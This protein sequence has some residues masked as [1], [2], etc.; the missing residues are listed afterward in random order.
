MFALFVNLWAAEDTSSIIEES[1]VESADEELAEELEE[2]IENPINI[3]KATVEELQAIPDITPV[4]AVNIVKTR[5]SL[6]KFSNEDDLMKVPGMS[7]EIL[8]R[9][10]PF[11]V[12]QET[13][14]QKK[15]VFRNVVFDARLRYLYFWKKDEFPKY[16]DKFYFR[17]R[18]RL[19]RWHQFGTLLEKDAGEY[20]YV[21]NYKIS[22]YSKKLLFLSGLALGN[23]RIRVGQGLVLSDSTSG[24]AMPGYAVKAAKKKRVGLKMDLSST[25]NAYLFGIGAK[26][27]TG[28]VEII[29]FFSRNRYDASLNDDGTVKTLFPS[30]LDGVHDTASALEKKDRLTDTSF[31]ADVSI[32]IGTAHRI[33]FTYLKSLLSPPRGLTEEEILYP[34]RVFEGDTK[35]VLGFNWDLYFSS[36]NIYG[37]IAKLLGYGI[38]A[39]G[40]LIIDFGENSACLLFR[41]YDPNFYNYHGAGF[42]AG[43][44]SCNEQGVYAG[45]T[46]KSGGKILNLF[47]DSYR[48]IWNEDGLTPWT[49]KVYSE[50]QW[51]KIPK[52]NLTFR[53]EFKY[54]E[55]QEVNTDYGD[56][57][58]PTLTGKLRTQIAWEIPHQIKIRFRVEAKRFWELT[59]RKVSNT[60][61]VSF[62]DI[63]WPI[64]RES[65]FY[66]RVI[67]SW[68]EDYKTAG[69]YEFQNTVPGYMEIVYH[70][71]D[72]TGFYLMWRTAIGPAAKLA[73]KWAVNSEEPGKDFAEDYPKVVQRFYTQF[74]VRW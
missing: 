69:V 65:T 57:L 70:G 74:D 52:I 8:E 42:S 72:A 7:A 35:N 10:R 17:F 15:G 12:F 27:T 20:N 61:I 13:P 59:G 36:L 14:I 44:L 58:S 48:D 3:N 25:E 28:P 32:K 64:N 68:V 18:T 19:G 30:Q 31:G 22:F 26:I 45:F 33:G 43:T 24:K 40:G 66:A 37:E 4:L 1:V 21:D 23:Y 71:E 53:S 60:G 6:G 29:P 51:L 55:L 39:I 38:G 49:Y 9:I 50:L 63:V 62:F 73:L 46:S 56:E 41:H 54:K 67:S 11:I 5:N 47:I 34:Y 2:L 16:P